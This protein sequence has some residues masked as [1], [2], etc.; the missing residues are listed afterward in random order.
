MST[1]I[2]I[3]AHT[4][5]W[6]FV[7][8]VLVLVLAARNF[9]TRTISAGSLFIFPAIL[10]LLAV[11]NVVHSPLG[12]LAAGAEL[13][14]AGAVG[15]AVAW[16]LTPAPLE[17][18]HADGQIVLPASAIPFVVTLLIVALRYTFGYLYG[19]WPELRA[20]PLD[21]A[22]LV[23]AGAFLAGLNLG[24]ISRIAWLYHRRRPAVASIG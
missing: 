12:P 8:I 4:P 24:R 16:L 10:V 23:G 7:V 22:I 20:D 6:A 13:L 15:F 14:A 21:A 18:R 11:I 2:T 3:L 17:F 5:P 19:R 9:R 1:V